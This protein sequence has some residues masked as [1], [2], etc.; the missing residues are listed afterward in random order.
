MPLLLV[1]CAVGEGSEGKACS[2]RLARKC[3][4]DNGSDRPDEDMNKIIF[5]PKRVL[6]K[7]F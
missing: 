6:C 1:V 5:L 4:K 2:C 7:N 3:T